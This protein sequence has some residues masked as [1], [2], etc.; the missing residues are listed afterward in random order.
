VFE[1]EFRGFA[2]DEN[3]V[4]FGNA[5]LRRLMESAPYD[6]GC[7]AV[8]EYEASQY[9]ASITIISRYGR[10]VAT[11]RAESCRMALE[12]VEDQIYEQLYRWQRGRFQPIT[13]EERFRA[14][15]ALESR[16][17]RA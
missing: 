7:D 11:A 3:L 15:D 8:V 16:R 4:N 13:D 6:S 10:F 9:L 2:P 12:S 5:L 14:R 1:I 17:K